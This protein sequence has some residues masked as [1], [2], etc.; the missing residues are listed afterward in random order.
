MPKVGTEPKRRAALV[1]AT[2]Q[3]IGETGSLDVTVAQIARRA[4]MSS[5][6][7]HHYFGSKDEIFLAAM[8]HILGDFGAHIRSKLAAAK[9]PRARV[10][11]VIQASFD[12]AHFAPHII[13]AWMA[14]YMRAQSD[15]RTARLLAIYHARMRSNLVHD[16]RPLTRDAEALA[17][18]LGAL[19]DGLYIRHALAGP[20]DGARAEAQAT[21]VLE[22]ALGEPPL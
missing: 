16:L 14:F 10:Q 2:I 12:E 22:R 20:A 1:E 6:L 7:A 4:G 18:T 9:N 5:A 11:A 8:R 3:E 15:A 19:I 17:D 21:A 13:A